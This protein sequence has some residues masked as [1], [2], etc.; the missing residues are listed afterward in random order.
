MCA[1]A[2]TNSLCSVA[3]GA[4]VISLSQGLFFARQMLT[5]SGV[6]FP[7]LQMATLDATVTPGDEK[8]QPFDTLSLYATGRCREGS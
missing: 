1:I 6:K 8:F 4:H 5:A 2:G 7:N 3:G